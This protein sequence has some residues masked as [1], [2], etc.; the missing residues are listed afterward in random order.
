MRVL[1]REWLADGYPKKTL[2]LLDQALGHAPESVEDLALRVRALVSL[3]DRHEAFRAVRRVAEDPRSRI[4]ELAVLAERLAAI[5]DPV[6]RQARE[7]ER[8]VITDLEVALEQASSAPDSM[9]SELDTEA[10]AV[11]ASPML[12][13]QDY[14]SGLPIYCCSIIASSGQA[15]SAGGANQNARPL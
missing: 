4:W 1:A 12:A 9:L 2:A 7:L 6:L 13:Q 5:Q 8:A 14:P 10:A 11:L 15:Q 3:K